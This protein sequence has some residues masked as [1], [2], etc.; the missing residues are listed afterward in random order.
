M[1][2]Y[3]RIDFKRDTND[4]LERAAVENSL[5]FRVTSVTAA[6]PGP[7]A[8]LPHVHGGWWDVLFKVQWGLEKITS[9]KSHTMTLTRNK[10]VTR[11]GLFITC[12]STDRLVVQ[13]NLPQNKRLQK[14]SLLTL[15]TLSP[16]HAPSDRQRECQSGWVMCRGLFRTLSQLV[17]RVFMK[18]QL[19]NL[20]GNV[21]NL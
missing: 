9:R 6:W 13:G 17:F 12:L 1:K 7:A 3:F 19:K 15:Y 20:S 4:R 14:V 18:L 11:A 2:S 21:W 10:H 16:S 8:C 5:Q